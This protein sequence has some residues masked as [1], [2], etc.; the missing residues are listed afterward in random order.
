MHMHDLIE[1]PLSEAAM[2]LGRS[3]AQTWRLALTGELDARKVGGRWYVTKVSIA[4]V[5]E[6]QARSS[7]EGRLRGTRLPSTQTE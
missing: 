4:Q 7:E 5:R 2:S 6:L 1:V 3:W